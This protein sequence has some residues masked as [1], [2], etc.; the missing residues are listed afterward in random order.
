MLRLGIAPGTG[1]GKGARWRFGA[2]YD[3]IQG[4]A[5]SAAAGGQNHGQKQGDKL[6]CLHGVE[7]P[8]C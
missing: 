2:G 5:F 1:R 4:I 7:D 3:T 8:V 6:V